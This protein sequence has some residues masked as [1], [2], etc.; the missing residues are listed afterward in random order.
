MTPV[1]GRVEPVRGAKHRSR[2]G[3]RHRSPRLAERRDPG[4]TLARSSD[5]GSLPTASEL[6][7]P[8]LIADE[9]PCG[10]DAAAIVKAVFEYAAAGFTM[11]HF[12]Q[13]GPDQSGFLAWWRDEL[14]DAVNNLGD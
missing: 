10:D 1:G 6:V 2:R 7:T 3:G 9:I 8:E 4:P 12:H 5:A 11:L 13:V 14:S